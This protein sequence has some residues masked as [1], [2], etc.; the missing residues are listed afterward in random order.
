ARRCEEFARNFAVPDEP[1][2]AGS[3]DE[4]AVGGAAFATARTASAHGGTAKGRLVL[5]LSSIWITARHQSRRFLY[6]RHKKSP[7]KPGFLNQHCNQSLDVT[8][9]PSRFVS[10]FGSDM[11]SAA[12]RANGT[13]ADGLAL[14]VMLF[15]LSRNAPTACIACAVSSAL[16]SCPS[17]NGNTA[18][19]WLAM[20]PGFMPWVSAK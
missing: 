20:S 13:G 5:S 4:C 1:A 12:R 9:I 11:T 14:I 10:S 18:F 3:S 8:V 2:G 15:G 6:G 7:D 17:R 19:A 16:P